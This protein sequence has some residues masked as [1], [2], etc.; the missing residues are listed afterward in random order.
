LKPSRDPE[1]SFAA[2]GFI[3]AI[4]AEENRRKSF[5]E[6]AETL[7]RLRS[8]TVLRLEELEETIARRA[9]SVNGLTRNADN[10]T[11]TIPA[12]AKRFA[13]SVFSDEAAQELP[14]SRPG[15]GCAISVR[16]GEKRS[17]CKLYD[18]T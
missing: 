9:A 3:A 4:E 8:A 1:A 7:L 14:P 10:W 18:M 11:D 5:L 15:L 13:N 2:G 16:D 12:F 17:T 6:E